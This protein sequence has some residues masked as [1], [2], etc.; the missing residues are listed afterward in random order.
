[1][2]ELHGVQYSNYYNKVKFVLLEQGIAFEEIPAD[3]PITDE[4]TLAHTPVGKIPFIRTAEGDLSESQVIVEYL[5]AC[6]P[7][8]RILPASPF[9]AAKVRELVAVLELHLELP[10]RELYGQMLLG[11]AVSDETKAR[12]ERILT[13]NIAGFKR[14]AKFAPYLGGEAWTFAD[15]AAYV[16]LPPIGLAT[17]T[18][19]GRDMLL[20]ADIDWK[21]YV[22]RIEDERPAAQRI[23]ADRKAAMAALTPSKGV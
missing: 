13:R 7:D 2:I 16:S 6:H 19:L 15:I 4:A 17:K 14:I 21:T 5:S 22:K 12:I 18:V 1:M 8:K 20:E 11:R 23:A 10:A 9:E 3:L